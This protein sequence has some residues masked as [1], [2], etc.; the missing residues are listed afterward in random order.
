MFKQTLKHIWPCLRNPFLQSLRSSGDQ[1]GY[2]P[3]GLCR[4]SC[5]IS[6]LLKR[7]EPANWNQRVDVVDNMSKPGRLHRFGK[8]FE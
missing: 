7:E 1:V 8:S 6:T 4:H 2:E 5:K 3:P